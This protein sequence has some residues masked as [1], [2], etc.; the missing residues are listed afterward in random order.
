MNVKNNFFTK[1]TPEKIIMNY[2]NVVR[3]GVTNRWKLFNLDLSK[4]EFFEVIGGLLGRQGNL[5][6]Q[7]AKSPL[8]WNG[9]PPTK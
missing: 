5:A 1:K 8:I 9:N 3:Q 4:M 2:C 6:I 7:F